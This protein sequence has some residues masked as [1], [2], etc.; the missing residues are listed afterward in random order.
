MTNSNTIAFNYSRESTMQFGGSGVG[1]EV[2]PLRSGNQKGF[3]TGMAHHV[4]RA[5]QYLWPTRGI[6]A[7]QP[8]KGLS[9]DPALRH[10][11]RGHDQNPNACP[12]ALRLDVVRKTVF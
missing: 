5:I 9:L 11:C 2:P 4:N 12:P 10:S 6:L 8:A 7:V 1:R 3:K